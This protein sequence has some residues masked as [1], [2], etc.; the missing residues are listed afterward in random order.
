MRTKILASTFIALLFAATAATLIL[1]EDSVPSPVSTPT[2]ITAHNRKSVLN[3]VQNTA[4]LAIEGELQTLYQVKK[5]DNLFQI[6]IKFD[7][8]TRAIRDANK[9][10]NNNLAEGEWLVIPK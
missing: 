7:V 10:I 5:G 9:S 3:T 2:H 8:S 1:R 4:S 6:A